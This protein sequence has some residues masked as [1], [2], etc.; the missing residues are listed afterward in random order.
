VVITV[1]PAP[2]NFNAIYAY[3]R[4]LKL[5]SPALTAADL[6]KDGNYCGGVA[7]SGPPPKEL[8]GSRGE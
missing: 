1:D 8:T 4:H 3:Q 5:V 6:A 2:Q 7:I